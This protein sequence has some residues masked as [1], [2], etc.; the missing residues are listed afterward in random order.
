MNTQKIQS[1]G[2]TLVELI[3]VITILVILGTIAFINLGGQSASARD[4][5]RTSDVRNL[6]SQVNIKQTSGVNFNDMISSGSTN[7]ITAGS[8]YVGGTGVLAAKYGVDYTAG[9]PSYSVLGVSPDNF[10]DPGTKSDYA[11]GATTLA[12]GAYQIAATLE[13]DNAKSAL[14]MGTFN[15]RK[16]TD[17]ASGTNSTTTITLTTGKGLFKVNDWIG[18]GTA[19][20]QITAVS[21]DLGTL[22]TSIAIPSSPAYKLATAESAGLI[23]DR[24]TKTTGVSNGS[25][26]VYP[27]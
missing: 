23:A 1:R 16:S 21:A 17:T 11:M 13:G 10:K 4:S 5:K 26:T 7:Q 22:T 19:T 8:L 18:N 14:V 15:S 27:Y 3:V 2:F 9:S 24:T 25:T 6:V 20:G 12:G